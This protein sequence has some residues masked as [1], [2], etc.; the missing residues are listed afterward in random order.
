[1][2]AL[3]PH[4]CC[5]RQR[6]LLYITQ[7]RSAETTQA[8][9]VR[10]GTLREWATI[11]GVGTATALA[12]R[13]DGESDAWKC[14]FINGVSDYVFCFR[15]VDGEVIGLCSSKS[16]TEHYRVYDV[17]VKYPH[18]GIG[19]QMVQAPVDA[20]A[21][22]DQMRICRL[23]RTRNLELTSQCAEA[24]YGASIFMFGEPLGYDAR[25]FKGRRVRFR[26]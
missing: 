10:R 3:H 20:L 4:S 6:P 12:R 1:M 13:A 19:S 18:N 9:H 8:S 11:K 23:G 5:T 25:H 2:H 26:M 17:C 16:D 24:D 22:T 14:E 21:Q 15:R 7:D